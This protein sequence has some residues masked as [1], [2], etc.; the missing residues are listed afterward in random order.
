MNFTVPINL[1]CARVLR[2]PMSSRWVLWFG[3][4]R[5]LQRLGQRCRDGAGEAVMKTL[6]DGWSSFI[7]ADLLLCGVSLVRR[8]AVSGHLRANSCAQGR[9]RGVHLLQE[10]N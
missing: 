9:Q 2:V 1:H 10:K 6:S 7:R 5:A 3:D 4:P 8:L